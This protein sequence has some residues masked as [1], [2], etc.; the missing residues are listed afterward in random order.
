MC[1]LQCTGF[2]AAGPA[3]EGDVLKSVMANHRRK[4]KAAI[5]G[6]TPWCRRPPCVG[7]GNEEG[8]FMRMKI[9]RPNF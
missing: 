9:A 2:F 8:R 3:K 6:L 4:Q 5:H 1:F 7:G